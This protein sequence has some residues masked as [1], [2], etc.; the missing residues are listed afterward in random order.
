M[1]TSFRADAGAWLN[2][3]FLT[4]KERDIETG[5]DYFGARYY[6]STQGRF[7]S[8]DEPF[9]GQDEPDPQTWNLYSYTSNNPLNRSDEDGNRWF[10][11][12]GKD[13]AEVQWVNPNEDG[14]YTSPGEGWT[15]FV[16]TDREPFLIL[17][18]ADGYHNYYFGEKADGS[19][20]AR[21]LWTGVAENRPD[22]ILAA[23]FIFQDL[24]NLA[25][26]SFNALRATETAAV[27]EAVTIG[28]AGATTA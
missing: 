28:Q 4:S 20:D 12:Q 21:T 2:Y 26:L 11:R 16:P 10:Y 22:H 23:V 3:P 27:K 18:S 6:S 14:T 5:L 24:F 15:E 8:P 9:I 13:G 19:P 17:H 25:R 7:T 1:T